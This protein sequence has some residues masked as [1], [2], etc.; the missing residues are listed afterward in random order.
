MSYEVRLENF[1]GPL[2]LLLS[3]VTSAKIEIR[4]IFVSEITDQYLKM[5]REAQDL[6]MD[7]SSE[8][9][10]V[11]S[12]LIYIKSRSLLP[13]QERDDD[14]DENGLT[15]EERFIIRLE[16]YKRYK[17]V[18]EK[19]KEFEKKGSL[20]RYKLPEELIL[21][22]D[23]SELTIDSNLI[24]LAYTRLLGRL[25]RSEETAL[26]KVRIREEVFTVESQAKKITAYLRVYG[27]MT[28]ESV[29]SEMPTEEELVTTFS[30]LLE[31]LHSG[32]I[33]A[34]QEK[35]FGEI[36]IEKRKS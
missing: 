15:P 36:Y 24:Y 2:D 5:M 19:L 23:D 1:E 18:S 22:T 29:L 14:I 6:T 3:L 7:S 10:Q 31:M 21:D 35:T 12:E 13:K 26:H 30:A 25:K 8:F 16:Q 34:Y 17:E 9:L 33:H 27:K 4:D 20:S 28:F 32:Q 11:A